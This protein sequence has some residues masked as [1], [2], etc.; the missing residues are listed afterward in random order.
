M[1]TRARVC[2]KVEVGDLVHALFNCF[3]R[4][5]EPLELGIGDTNSA[6]VEIW[7][8]QR[9]MGGND[10]RAPPKATDHTAGNGAG[11]EEKYNFAPIFENPACERP[12]RVAARK[13]QLATRKASLSL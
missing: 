10:N 12:D 11:N 13:V 8:S 9:L 2:H 6:Y 7:S 4:Y 1:E 3:R 5:G